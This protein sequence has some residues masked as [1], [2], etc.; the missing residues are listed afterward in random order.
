[1]CQLSNIFSTVGWYNVI[2][3]VGEAVAKRL[4]EFLQEK[5]LTLYKLAKDAYLPVSTLFNLYRK[6]TKSPTL[7]VMLKI[8]DALGITMNEFLDSPLFSRDNLELE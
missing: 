2:M 6:H 3:T 5:N 4:D 8:V 1:M 7:T